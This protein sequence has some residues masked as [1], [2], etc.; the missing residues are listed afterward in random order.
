MITPVFLENA[1]S[2]PRVVS[3]YAKKARGAMARFVMQNKI[4]TKKELMA[5]DFGG[6]AYQPDLSDEKTLYFVR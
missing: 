5:F 6:Y 3:F 2:K 1:P 4:T